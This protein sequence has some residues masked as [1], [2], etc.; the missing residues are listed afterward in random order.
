MAIGW[1]GFC[2]LIGAA[3]LVLAASAVA[4][5]SSARSDIGAAPGLRRVDLLARLDREAQARW[6][7]GALDQAAT[8][9]RR[10]LRVTI[11]AYGSNS[12][13][14]AEA[15]DRL[16][17]VDIDCG[18]Y[19]DA[20]PLLILADRI[21]AVHAASDPLLVTVLSGLAR[22]SVA[23]GDAPAAIAWA[24]RAVAIA[25]RHPAG[26]SGVALRA[27]G[28]ALAA[29]QQFGEAEQVLDRA[30]A[31]ADKR[32]GGD[33]LDLARSLSQLANVYLRQNRAKAALPLL[34][35]AAAID[36]QRL[37]PTHPFIADDFHDLGLAY[38]Q[39]KREAEAERTFRAALGVLER[40][41]GRDTPRVA[42]VEL[43]LS[44]LYRQRGDSK[45]ADPVYRDARRILNKAEA[46]E[47]K[48]QRRV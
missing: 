34:Q 10:I 28:A 42:Y 22:V 23:H 24:R 18:R 16:A 8:L 14:A 47:H 4:S 43:E 12:M 15:M 48:R 38:D 29:A 1:R 31:A 39:L 9:R 2:R 6:Y 45:A 17:A 44:R 13:P 41:A 35:R 36:Q 37:G 32:R 30:V 46:E 11:A 26:G 21:L 40:G 19:L 7:D 25:A 27:L 3:V 20:E 33:R 5:A